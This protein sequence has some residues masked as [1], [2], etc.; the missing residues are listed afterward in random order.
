M[1]VIKRILAIGLLIVFVLCAARASADGLEFRVD[2]EVFQNDEK[3]PILEQLTIFSAD[4]AVYDFQLTAPL[5][6]TVFD[7]RH[8][9][10]TLLDETR[11]VKAVISTQSIMDVSFELETF[12]AKQKHGLAAFCAAPQFETTA[13][14]VERSGQAMVELRLV[15]K[16]LSF[17]TAGLKSPHPDAA[18]N[19][20]YFADWCARLNSVRG[21]SLPASARLALN[22]EFAERELLPFE[23][24]RTIP[25][26]TPL[27]KKIEH[28]SEHRFNWTLS[29]E[30]RKKIEG[31]SDMMATFEA[32][33]FDKYRAADSKSAA[34]TPK[35]VRR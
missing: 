8:G 6:T 14:D 16:P 24:V 31:A 11:K 32:V 1:V 35:Q 19:Y 30:D 18:K 15:A 21:F 4:G 33:T 26:P 22:K 29:G 9:R 23:I 5:E 3:K 10:F 13:E 7:P 2:T 20:R 12:A 27:G 34:T 17:T 28:K 25:A